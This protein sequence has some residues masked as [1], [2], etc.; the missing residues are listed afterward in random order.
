[1]V[2]AVLIKNNFSSGELS[3][4]LTTR[5]DVQQYNNGA[6]ALTN[7]IPLIEGGVEWRSLDGRGGR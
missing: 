2:K 4:L 3:P 1:M 6:K 5:T 7:I